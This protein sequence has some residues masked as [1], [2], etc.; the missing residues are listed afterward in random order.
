MDYGFTPH[1][2]RYIGKAKSQRPDY[3]GF[4]AW[5]D[6]IVREDLF[7]LVFVLVADVVAIVFFILTVFHLPPVAH[8]AMRYEDVHTEAELCAY[9]KATGA[10]IINHKTCV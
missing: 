4:F 6:K 2:E 9:V 7:W 1:E 8:A 3:C 5:R 10:T